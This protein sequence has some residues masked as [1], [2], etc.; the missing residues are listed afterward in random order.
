MS[1]APASMGNTQESQPRLSGS[2]DGRVRTGQ[3]QK[4]RAKMVEITK[5]AHCAGGLR[6]GPTSQG[7]CLHGVG[8][9]GRRGLLPRLLLRRAT[10]T[11]T[12]IH[13]VLSSLKSLQHADT[14]PLPCPGHSVQLELGARC[15]SCLRWLQKDAPSALEKHKLNKP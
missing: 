13:S 1:C 3:P 14:S 5:Q 7:R 11:R 12:D 2:V 15:H 9:P 10:V 4:G 8:M 6:V